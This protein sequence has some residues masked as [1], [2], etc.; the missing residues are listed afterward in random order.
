MAKFITFLTLPSQEK[1]FFCKA[2][3]LQIYFRLLL[4]NQP[5]KKII[6]KAS[7]LKQ[8]N[9]NRRI[10]P[11]ITPVKAC[12]LT[13]IAANLTPFATCFSRSLAGSIALASLGLESTIHIGVLK[14]RT[15]PFSAHAW[16]IYDDK[17]I[18]GFLPN[19]KEFTPLP[20]PFD[21][22]SNEPHR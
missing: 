3:G 10:D 15:Q 8:H 11:T 2:L 14:N 19:L 12:Q 17:L 21:K 13:H 5:F 9:L 1:I 16:L 22:M 6:Y 7:R 20:S 4:F 18:T